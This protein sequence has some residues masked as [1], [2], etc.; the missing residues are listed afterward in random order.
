MKFFRSM[1][2][3][4]R[5]L[6]MCFVAIS[7]FSSVVYGQSRAVYT[8]TK[9]LYNFETVEEWQPISNASR[10]MF[11]GTKK[12]G[13]GIEMTYPNIRL[14]PTK[15]FGLGNLS[16]GSTNSLGVSVLFD[17]KAYNFFDLVP[18]DQKLMD[19]QTKNLN[20]WV[21]G[22]NFDYKMEIL[23][24]DFKGYTH[25]FDLGSLR[26]AGWRNLEATI[27]TYIA[28]TEEH[29]PSVRG[30]RFLNFRFWSSPDTKVENF[31]VLL[32]YFQVIMNTYRE[33]YD[34][35]D[36]EQALLK[37][38]QDSSGD[39]NTSTEEVETEAAPAVVN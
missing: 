38:E 21:W 5:H 31:T 37:E 35:Y 4:A 12:N 34:G 27:P 11:T 22:G 18:T 23:V 30:L 33:S 28:Q 39:D 15:P 3:I 7:V 36:V 13:N 10:F 29:L 26:Y 19:G 1:R 32:D 20:V 16:D 9:V 2:L 14:F 24:E 8:E 17:R 6:L 25:T